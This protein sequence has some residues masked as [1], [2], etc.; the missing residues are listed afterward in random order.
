MQRAAVSKTNLTH[1]EIV[2]CQN[3]LIVVLVDLGLK[4]R[5][6]LDLVVSHNLSINSGLQNEMSSRETVSVEIAKALEE[7]RKQREELQQQVG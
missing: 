6:W 2:V 4:M 7:T 5:D 1:L 3:T